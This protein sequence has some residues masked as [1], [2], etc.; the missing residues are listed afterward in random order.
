V[1]GRQDD[2]RADLDA[3]TAQ[4]RWEWMRE[5]QR[6]SA[7][8][9][10]DTPTPPPNPVK[11]RIDATWPRGPRSFALHPGARAQIRSNSMRVRDAQVAGLRP[12]EDHGPLALLLRDGDGWW[13][14]RRWPDTDTWGDDL[15]A[16]SVEIG[17]P[18][19]LVAATA[20]PVA[21]DVTPLP[22]PPTATV[23]LLVQTLG[24]QEQE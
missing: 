1:S 8:Q 9:F 15:H 20:W 16:T 5:Q 3:M 14:L 17:N 19:P 23:E 2:P 13:A 22:A 18:N 21:D 4:E 24:L 10:K 11:A 12:V 6:R 7:E